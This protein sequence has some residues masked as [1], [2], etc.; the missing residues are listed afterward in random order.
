ML[1]EG[2]DKRKALLQRLGVEQLFNSTD[3]CCITSAGLGCKREAIAY[4]WRETWVMQR[5][6]S[7]MW[8]GICAH[9]ADADEAMAT[10]WPY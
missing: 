6:S 3:E 5:Y 10:L 7:A 4:L 9:C 2:L 8:Y 1:H